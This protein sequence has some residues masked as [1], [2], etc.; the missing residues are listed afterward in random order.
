M[1][2]RKGCDLGYP[3]A[4]ALEHVTEPYRPELFSGKNAKQLA[5]PNPRLQVARLLTIRNACY[6]G[7]Q[8]HIRYDLHAAV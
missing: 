2:K 4:W 1:V 6:A 7:W 5:S 3:T 8:L